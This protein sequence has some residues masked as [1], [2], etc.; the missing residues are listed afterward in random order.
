MLLW[1]RMFRDVSPI[2]QAAQ[3]RV[4]RGSRTTRHTQTLLPQLVKAKGT[5]TTRPPYSEEIYPSK[6][7]SPSVADPVA[8]TFPSDLQDAH[9]EDL[10]ALLGDVTLCCQEAALPRIS[11]RAVSFQL[12]SLATNSRGLKDCSS[13]PPR[14]QHSPWRAPEGMRAPREHS[15]FLRAV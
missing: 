2:P 10:T 7:S 6:R 11:F 9:F 4:Y 13:L 14:E 1:Y 5:H 15:F 8:L 3:E 12:G